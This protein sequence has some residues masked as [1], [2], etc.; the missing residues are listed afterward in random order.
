MYDRC[1]MIIIINKN[2]GLMFK[3]FKWLCFL[4]RIKM[5]FEVYHLMMQ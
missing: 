2:W 5:I 1:D 4:N 3:A